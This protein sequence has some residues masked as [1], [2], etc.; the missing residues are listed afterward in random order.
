MSGVL[1]YPP[2]EGENMTKRIAYKTPQESFTNRTV[3]QGNCLIW[4]GAE[5]D[6]GYGIIWAGKKLARAH[7]YAWEQSN[8][9]IPRGMQIDHMCFNRKCCEVKHLRLATTKQNMEH[10]KGP[11]VTNPSGIRGV[12]WDRSSKKW[13]VRVKHNYQEFYGGMF[14]S[15]TE[16]ESAAIELRNR[17]FSHNLLD[18]AG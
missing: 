5:T 3:R 9:P 17:L 13:R 8:G 18:R 12:S 14:L 4:T 7:R 15:L 2:L 11:R 10:I 6:T 16:A 1:S